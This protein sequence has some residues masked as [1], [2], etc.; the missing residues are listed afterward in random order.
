M[1]ISRF[2]VFLLLFLCFSIGIFAG[3]DEKGDDTLM[4]EFQKQLS[5]FADTT[6]SIECDFKQLKTLNIL[7]DGIVSH[8][9]FYCVVEKDEKSNSRFSIC[10]NYTEPPENQIVIKNGKIYVKID[11]KLVSSGS[12]V[13]PSIRQFHTLLEVCLTGDVT[14]F[15]KLEKGNRIEISK[16]DSLYIL[17]LYPVSKSMQKKLKKMTLQF[18]QSDMLL[19]SL[20]MEES[21]GDC[22]EYQFSNTVINKALSEKLFDIRDSHD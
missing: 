3:E 2:R 7:T 8:G 21:N 18:N 13:N 19:H 17:K 10:L 22:T 15:S 14:L 12:K 4:V 5:I 20:S 6:R 16:T 9:K 11:G 1:K